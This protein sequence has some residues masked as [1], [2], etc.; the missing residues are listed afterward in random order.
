MRF[1]VGKKPNLKLLYFLIS[2]LTDFI[3]NL[4]VKHRLKL[5]LKLK[6]DIHVTFCDAFFHF[7]LR[8]A[9]F[10][11]NKKVSCKAKLW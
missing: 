2:N 11:V 5:S 9:L 10:Q 7:K 4:N 6:A 3:M 1:V 8:A